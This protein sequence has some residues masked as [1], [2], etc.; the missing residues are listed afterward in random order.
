MSNPK[1]PLYR[2][3]DKIAWKFGPLLWWGS[4]LVALLLVGALALGLHLT[5]DLLIAFVIVEVILIA[6]FLLW[7]HTYSLPPNLARLF[8]ERMD[9]G[10]GIDDLLQPLP[11]DWQNLFRLAADSSALKAATD[12]VPGAVFRLTRDEMDR[13]MLRIL[14][15]GAGELPAWVMAVQPTQEDATFFGYILSEDRLATLESVEESARNQTPWV[16]ECRVQPPGGSP[17]WVRFISHPRSANGGQIT[18][19]GLMLDINERKQAEQ[20]LAGW[21]AYWKALF[22]LVDDGVLLDKNGR[23]LDA[24]HRTCEWLGIKRVDLLE[25][26]LQELQAGDPWPAEV[27]P[28]GISFEAHILHGDRSAL[29]V[30]VSRSLVHAG[31]QTLALTLL[32]D[33]SETRRTEKQLRH[34]LTT[35]ELTGVC[36]RRQYLSLTDKEFK[37]S[38][39]TGEFFA[40]IMLDIDQ[41][42]NINETFGHSAG[43]QVL[44]TMAHILQENVRDIDIVGRIGGEEFAITLVV[45]A[46]MD[47]AVDTA[48]KIRNAIESTVVRSLAGEIKLSVSA[49]VAILS[50]ADRNLSIMLHRA[51]QALYA[52]KAGGR[53]CIMAR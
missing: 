10:G 1:N 18:W 13:Y 32:R 37:R 25:K 39:R 15:V 8:F 16:H 36:N 27:P 33:L 20:T 44:K 21:D 43:D 45:C 51:D 7:Q 19:E 29:P 4:A 26:D 9:A 42:K 34:L 23:L 24:S 52:A 6:G 22:E 3:P 53:N 46:D 50:D 47:E 49:G 40:V 17:H 41:F 48:E 35:D 28:E 12:S 14:R 2:I 5:V 11:V 30:R 31:E 38:R